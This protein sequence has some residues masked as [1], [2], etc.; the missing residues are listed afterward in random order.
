M[1][2]TRTLTDA[3]QEQLASGEGVVGLA[4]TCEGDSGYGPC[5]MYRDWAGGTC[6]RGHEIEIRV[7]DV[8]E[9]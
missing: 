9:A 8:E 1:S 5:G 2:E 7:D 3:E 4:V 6:A